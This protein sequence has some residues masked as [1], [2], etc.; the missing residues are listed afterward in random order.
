MTLSRATDAGHTQPPANSQ[1]NAKPSVPATKASEASERDEAVAITQRLQLAIMQN[2]YS[3]Y[4]RH[5][6]S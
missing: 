2:I 6:Y 5:I 4:T 1:S 3:A